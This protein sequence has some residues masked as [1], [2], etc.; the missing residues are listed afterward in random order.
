MILI[1]DPNNNSL[2][3]RRIARNTLL[4]YIR[5][6]LMLLIGLYTSRVVLKTLG[7]SDYGLYNVVGGMVVMFSF[8]NSAMVAASQRFISYELGCGDKKRLNHVF[9]TSIHIHAI[10]A[11]V[12]LVLA[13]TAGLWFVNTQL[14]I[15]AGRMDAANWV[16]QFSILTLVVNVMSV[17][18]NS[19]IVAHE[20]M[21]VFAYIGI[22][23]AFLKLGVV[24]LLLAFDYDK[25][26]LYASLVFAV[27]VLI[28]MLYSVYCKKN[29]EECSYHL[30]VDKSLLRRMLSFAGWSVV[31]NLGFSFKDQGSNIILNLFYGTSVNAARGISMQ[32]CGLVS[33]FSSNFSMALNPQITKQY[34]AGHISECLT[35][36][37][38]GARYTFY[39]L[40]LVSIPF[41]INMDYVLKLWLGNVP[42]HTSVFLALSMIVSMLYTMTGTVTTALQATGKVKVFQTGIC[43]I[44]L[45]ELPAAYIFL[46]WGYPPYYALY[47]G[48]LAG[49]VAVVFR[50]FLLKRYVSQCNMRQ[51]LVSVLLRCMTIFIAVWTFCKYVHSFFPNTFLTVVITSVFSVVTL[52][53]VIF[54]W[55]LSERERIVVRQKMDMLLQSKLC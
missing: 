6:S 7:V 21:K 19:C 51:Y 4:L 49:L 43:L 27:S 55:G 33:T 54:F 11:V 53:L 2:D 15:D 39:L 3:K 35:L 42:E 41:L 29:F 40:A 52:V 37:Y 31:G 12:I 24:F 44:M 30:S 26:I 17:P 23:E 22:V 45:L 9:C 18:Y 47:P 20:R 38:S 36:V 46:F 13:E 14:V 34:A 28:R 25:L 1:M 48:I 8:L 32:V 5:M 10:I 50:I 16:Y